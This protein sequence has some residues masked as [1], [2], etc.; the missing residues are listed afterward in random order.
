M[1]NRDI[2]F[3][4]VQYLEIEDVTSCS[5]VNK[6]IREISDAQ[7]KRFIISDYGPVFNFVSFKQSYVKCYYLNIFWKSYVTG[8]SLIDFY[9]FT[10]ISLSGR[11]MD[12]LPASIGQLSNLRKLWSQR[13]QIKEL[14]ITIGQL[15]S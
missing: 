15:S 7:Y 11:G 12:K 4:I 14:P 8:F 5:A 10:E 1:E 9:H 13:N 2:I 3:N 6:L